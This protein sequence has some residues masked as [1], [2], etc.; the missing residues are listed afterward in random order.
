MNTISVSQELMEEGLL[1][2]NLIGKLFST[3]GKA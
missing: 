3:G 1:V 2:P